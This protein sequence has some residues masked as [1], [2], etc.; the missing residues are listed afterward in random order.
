MRTC[1]CYPSH[2]LRPSH[3]PV[4]RN[5]QREASRRYVIYTPPHITSVITTNTTNKGV[6]KHTH[7]TFTVALFLTNNLKF[8]KFQ[9]VKTKAS[10]KRL[11]HYVIPTLPPQS[12]YTKSRYR[13]ED[14]TNVVIIY[15]SLRIFRKNLCFKEKRCEWSYTTRKSRLGKFVFTP[16][17]AF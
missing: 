11:F 7:E 4:R 2:S 17:I 1:T 9:R 8:A 6:W 3:C 5:E 15:D 12:V 10:S 14:V 16:M 13:R